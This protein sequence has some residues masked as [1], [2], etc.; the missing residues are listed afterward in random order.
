[1]FI[2]LPH[3]LEILEFITYIVLRLLTLAPR[4]LRNWA[5][6]SICPQSWL[7]VILFPPETWFN[8]G[9]KRQVV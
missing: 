3:T 1:M 2:M 5:T 8:W 7:P 4:L 9:L 6:H